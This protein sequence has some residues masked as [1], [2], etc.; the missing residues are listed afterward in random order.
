MSANKLPTSSKILIAALAI[1]F[2]CVLGVIGEIMFSAIDNAQMAFDSGRFIKIDVR[3]SQIEGNLAKIQTKQA[4]EQALSAEEYRLKRI[5][6]LTGKTEEEA[7]SELQKTTP[8]AEQPKTTIA[9]IAEKSN[10]RKVKNPLQLEQN[11]ELSRKEGNYLLPKI[12]K[13]GKT[14]PWQYYAKPSV[15]NKDKKTFSIII[16]N[17]GL[18]D[19]STKQVMLLDENI[20][21]AFSPYANNLKMQI[22]LARKNGFETWLN[23]P[24]QH[25]NYPIHDYG[26]LTL[27]NEV[28]ASDNIEQL[29]KIINNTNGI[30]GLVALPD[31][32][33]SGSNQMME[34]FEE[35]KKRG[36]LLALYSKIFTPAEHEQYVLA[37]IQDHI[38]GGNVPSDLNQ[39]FQEIEAKAKAGDHLVISMAAMPSVLQALNIW[40]AG[41]PEKNIILTPLST[42]GFSHVK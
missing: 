4:I 26:N 21:L 5:Q 16:T 35:I 6:E 27:L 12:S 25:E 34:I 37:N 2:L 17:V 13:D 18:N 31:E 38:N 33:Y 11:P 15:P 24:L 8:Q 40:L 19:E 14:T 42:Y 30:V 28:K 20:T 29:H 22:D 32:K 41:L 9:A 7:Q 39:L 36:L 23:L 10:M 3:N 1:Q